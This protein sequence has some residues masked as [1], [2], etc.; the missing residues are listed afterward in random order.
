MEVFAEKIF[1]IIYIVVLLIAAFGLMIVV[2]R[3]S[4]YLIRKIL[5]IGG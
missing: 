2:G 3:I 4:N 5:G 1:S